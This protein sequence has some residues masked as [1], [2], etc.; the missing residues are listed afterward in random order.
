MYSEALNLALRSKTKENQLLK[1][2]WV[3]RDYD[4]V[5]S[6]FKEL[7]E[8]R[9]TRV[10]CIIYVTRPLLK[11][12]FDEIDLIFELYG[13]WCGDWQSDV[14][15]L[16]LAPQKEEKN[17]EGEKDQVLESLLLVVSSNSSL[18][19]LAIEEL[20][21]VEFHEGRPDIDNI[22]KHEIT[23]SAGST[24]FVTCGHPA[25]VDDLRKSVVQHLDYRPGKRVDYYEQLEVWA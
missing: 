22:V 14:T 23:E 10:K 4:S 7:V 16:D 25:V 12:V 6:F 21:H 24:C 19:P 9:K 11:D 13:D 1:L 17:G 18:V 20:N 8:L 2:Y 15:V 5:K 3:I